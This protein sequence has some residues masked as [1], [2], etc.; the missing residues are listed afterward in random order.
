MKAS[1]VS[2]IRDL[3]INFL[4]IFLGILITFAIQAR[5][6]RSLDKKEIRSSLELV[7]NELAAN[8]EDIETMCDYVLE[9]RRSAEYLLAHKDNLAKCPADSVNYHG[10]VIFAD[11]SISVSSD[12]L[13][14]IRS[15]SMFQKIGDS[16]LSMKI[17]RAYD[18]CLNSAAILNN[19]VATRN[20][21]FA[22]SINEQN[23]GRIAPDGHI[24]VK[25]LIR[26]NYGLYA[27]RQT[28]ALALPEHY[29]DLSDV[30][31]ALSAIDGYLQK[32]HRIRKN[33]H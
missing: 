9:E 24:S 6:D 30:E 3:I 15:S 23:V 26:T 25:E 1:A 16:R 14:M 28:A 22:K 21:F 11:A 8:M 17:V 4:A 5:I 12:A 10:G 13:E 20:G 2:F 18:S 33:R 7:R 31:D 32:G 27:I 19:H 29:V